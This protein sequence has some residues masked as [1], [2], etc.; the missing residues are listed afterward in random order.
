MTYD[1]WCHYCDDPDD[2][3]IRP[4]VLL[5]YDAIMIPVLL[6]WCR[7]HAVPPTD[8]TDVIPVHDERYLLAIVHLQYWHSMIFYLIDVVFY[9]IDLLTVKPLEAW[10]CYCSLF[11]YYDAIYTLYSDTD[12]WCYYAMGIVLEPFLWCWWYDETSAFYINY[13]IQ[14]C[15]I[16]YSIH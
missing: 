12:T 2:L 14:L 13:S 8:D 5:F 1:T 3:L 10:W 11:F 6:W 15:L 16:L 4:D 9:A 7:I